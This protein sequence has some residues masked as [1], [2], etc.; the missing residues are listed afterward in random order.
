MSDAAALVVGMVF[1]FTLMFPL[2][3]AAPDRALKFLAGNPALVTFWNLI[4]W[5]AAITVV[6][7]LLPVYEW[8]SPGSPAL[9]LTAAA[10]GLIW[11]GLTG[12]FCI[13]AMG[14]A[15]ALVPV[16]LYPVLR[17]YNRPLAIGYVVFRGALETVTYL[18]IVAGWLLLV[19]LGQEYAAAG[20]LAGTDLQILGALISTAAEISAS[21][22]AVVFPMGAMMLYAVLYQ[23]KLIP[24]WLSVWGMVAVGLTL[25][26]SG[27]PGLAN[28]PDAMPPVQMA[29]NALTL[30]Q[31]MVMAVW[32]IAKGFNLSASAARP[33][34]TEASELLSAA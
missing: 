21:L 17:R 14:L 33:G 20:A 3:D 28:R 5:L 4:D 13:L 29:A 26:S 15:L 19:T 6:I 8:L 23:S 1:S 24:R 12:A 27:V 34:R 11:A 31:E 32:F 16:A 30:V 25:V 9:T 18:G 7:M 22:T 10:F 2:L